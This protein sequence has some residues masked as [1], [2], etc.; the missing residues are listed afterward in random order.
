VRIVVL[1]GGVLGLSI[2]YNLV[3]RG[4]QV[5]VIE[6]GYPGSGFSVR[7][8]GVVHSQWEN[9]LDIKLAKRSRELLEHLSIDLNFNIPFRQDGCLMLATDESELAQLKENMRKQECQRIDTRFLPKAGISAR[10]PYL[11]TSTVAGG[12][13]SKGDGVVHPFSVVFG[14][15][16]GLERYGG[17]LLRSTIVKGLKTKGNAICAVETDRGTYEADATVITTLLGASEALRSIGVTVPTTLRKHEMLATEPLKFFLKPAIQIQPNR[18]TVI[19]SLRG[20]V[21]CEMPRG[22]QDQGNDR[23]SSLEFLEDAATDLVRLIPALRRVRVLRP[24]AGM[25]E[26]TC[27]P[28][29]I[30]D[31]LKYENLW[32]VFADSSRRV[33][34]APAIGEMISKSILSEEASANPLSKSSLNLLAETSLS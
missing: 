30:L 26:S 3:I 17:K 25:V 11:N 32:G 8:I 29:P 16:H 7:G 4:A 1:G 5:Q 34:F 27:D 12:T 28:R 22:E 9:E 19:Q 6:G 23:S 31:K 2:G 14:Y 33:M 13:F 20:E 21:I 15:W 24:W 18:I 10:Y